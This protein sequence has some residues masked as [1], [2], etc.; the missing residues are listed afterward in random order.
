MPSVKA[1]RIQSRQYTRYYLF[2]CLVIRCSHRG[3][4]SL[5]E[6]WISQFSLIEIAL[7]QEESAVQGLTDAFSKK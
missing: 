5:F 6:F 2:R 1:F 3:R 7:A 4:A